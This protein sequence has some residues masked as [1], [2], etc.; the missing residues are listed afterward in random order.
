MQCETERLTSE[1]I[2]QLSELAQTFQRPAP[3]GTP[4]SNLLQ[5][6]DDCKAVLLRQSGWS[7]RAVTVTPNEDQLD[8]EEQEII[9]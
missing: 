7:L 5:F 4:S 3:A 9:L 1:N 6:M 2:V 8:H